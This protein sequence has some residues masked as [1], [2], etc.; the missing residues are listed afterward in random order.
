MNSMSFSP[1][2]SDPSLQLTPLRGAPERRRHA[3]NAWVLA[4][5]QH[6]RVSEVLEVLD[7]DDWFLAATG[8]GYRR[9]KRLTW[10]RV[11]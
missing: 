7:D 1:S 5:V 2:R 6:V 3:A 4:G 11:P 9:F 8:G 10:P